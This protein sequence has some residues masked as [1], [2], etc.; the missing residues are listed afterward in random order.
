[1]SVCP[2]SLSLR[3]ES[4]SDCDC[5]VHYCQKRLD[6]KKWCFWLQAAVFQVQ[7]EQCYG[8]W[9]FSFQT[10][11]WK[12]TMRYLGKAIAL[13]IDWAK[14]QHPLTKKR[15]K[16]QTCL[17]HLWSLW[18]QPMLKWSTYII[19]HLCKQHWVLSNTDWERGKR[20]NIRLHLHGL[21]RKRFSYKS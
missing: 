5:S 8:A 21:L 19:V 2:L 11:Q 10:E 12:A 7:F 18:P 20:L 3:R 1:M 14:A 16:Y 4:S 6:Y 15:L 17:R 13:C 9:H